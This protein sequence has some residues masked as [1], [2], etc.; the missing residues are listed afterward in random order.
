MSSLVSVSLKTLRR[1][2][3]SFGVLYENSKWSQIALKSC[4]WLP[5]NVIIDINRRPRC[6]LLIDHFKDICEIIWLDKYLIRFK[7]IYCFILIGLIH[8]SYY[9]IRKQNAIELVRQCIQHGQHFK[10][11][12]YVIKYYCISKSISHDVWMDPPFIYPQFIYG[13]I[14][15]VFDSKFDVILTILFRLLMIY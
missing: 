2:E 5:E 15:I 3:V 1:N 12:L 10:V 8:F 7:S 9:Y 4:W 11:C 6:L 14:K 13:K